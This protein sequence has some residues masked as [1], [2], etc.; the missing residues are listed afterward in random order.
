MPVAPL[1]N[2]NKRIYKEIKNNPELTTP[3]FKDSNG[4]Q[5]HM[6]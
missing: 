5:D 2:I 6:L 1:E 4:V 3:T